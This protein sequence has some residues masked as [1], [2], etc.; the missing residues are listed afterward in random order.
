MSA[1]LPQQDLALA[2]RELALETPQD[3]ASPKLRK[4]A[5]QEQ[6]DERHAGGQQ[7]HADDRNGGPTADELDRAGVEE[8]AGLRSAKIP[9]DVI[10]SATTRA[11][12]ACLSTSDRIDP[13][14]DRRRGAGPC[15]G[16]PARLGRITSLP[17]ARTLPSAHGARATGTRTVSSRYG[18]GM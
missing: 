2:L 5:E 1:A 16:S 11:G 10:A 12:A 9:A 3:P 15:R 17:D 7:A 13:H 18:S 6:R 8:T 4:R 14:G